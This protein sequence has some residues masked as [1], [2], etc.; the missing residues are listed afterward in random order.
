MGGRT[1]T[2]AGSCAKFWDEVRDKVPAH[3]VRRSPGSASAAV[4][5]APD[6]QQRL[7]RREANV[8][9]SVAA[10]FPLARPATGKPLGL[11]LEAKLAV[12]ERR[13]RIRPGPAAPHVE[14]ALAR[15]AERS[16]RQLR[17]GRPE[18]RPKVHGVRKLRARR[19]R[20]ARR[21]AEEAGERGEEN[22][23]A[24]RAHAVIIAHLP[25]RLLALV[26]AADRAAPCDR[27][28]GHRLR[29]CP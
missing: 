22:D 11:V 16:V 23:R 26:G 4:G 10:V 21:D 12:L 7:R 3:G 1:R 20:R 17:V 25:D 6:E 13:Q 9:A 24:K 15:P 29:P 19:S 27:R 18:L 2:C 8:S 14:L 5:Q 28:L